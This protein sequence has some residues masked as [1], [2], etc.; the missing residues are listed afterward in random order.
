LDQ[1]KKKRSFYL[2][3]MPRVTSRG[4]A[5]GG[6]SQTVA[7]AALEGLSAEVGDAIGEG[8][9]RQQ[10]EMQDLHLKRHIPPPGH[11]DHELYHSV[12][13]LV[14][15]AMMIGMQVALFIWQKKNPLSFIRVTLLFLWLFPLLGALYFGW[16]YF[17]VAWMA[18]SG[19]TLYVVRLTMQR[20]LELATPRTVYR[21]FLASYRLCMGAAIAGYAIMI[22]DFLH[23][24]ALLGLESGT[25]SQWGTFIGF[26]GVYFGVLGRDVAEI[27]ADRMATSMGLLSVESFPSKR[28]LQSVCSLCSNLL[29]ER[30]SALNERVYKLPCDHQFHEACIRGWTIVGKKDSCP[31][32]SEKVDMRSIF[33]D[34]NP[35]TRGSVLWAHLLQA[36]R[37]ITVWNPILFLGLNLFLYIVD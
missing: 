5:R 4:A 32:C 10:L 20:P 9:E 15:F 11:E 8:L 33:P 3:E 1:K 14:I 12:L 22:V 26:L 34:G 24:S 36:C 18:Y 28:V 30:G 7:E 21:F 23:L 19:C 31:C 17:L 27:C 35:W 2:E 25:L 6:A 16:P 13:L 29:V 37:M